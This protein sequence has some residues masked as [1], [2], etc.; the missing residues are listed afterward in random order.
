MSGKQ[1]LTSSI[2]MQL[3]QNI[4][5][6]LKQLPLKEMNGADIFVA[7]VFY[8]T[9]GEAKINVAVKQVQKHWSKGVIGSSYNSSFMARAKGRVHPL[10]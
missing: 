2:N 5:T 7:I 9:G 1:A 4:T 10:A 8:L 6:F 3:P